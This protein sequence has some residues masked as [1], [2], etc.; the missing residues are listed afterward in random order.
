[1]VLKILNVTYVESRSHFSKF[2]RKLSFFFQLCWTV[3]H[4]VFVFQVHT[5]KAY[6]NSRS[7]PYSPTIVWWCTRWWALLLRYMP[8]S[9]HAEKITELAQ[10]TSTRAENSRMSYLRQKV[11]HTVPAYIFLNISLRCFNC[12]N[13]IYIFSNCLC[14]HV[15]THYRD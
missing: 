13:S 12:S 11:Q 2:R 15:T 7:K 14:R 10:N 6:F 9:V 4:F 3:V 8:E 1:M 5:K